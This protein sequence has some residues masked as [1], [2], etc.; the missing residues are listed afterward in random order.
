M[1]EAIIIGTGVIGAATALALVRAGW[2]V[3]S[4]DRNAVAG[5][6]S[7]S[8]SSGVV[9]MHYSTRE[10]TALAWEGTRHWQD[11]AGFL[12]LPA[13]ATLARFRQC[14][15]LVL[16]HGTNDGLA[17]EMAHGRALGIPFEEWDP[18]TI[19]DRWPGA[20]L[21]G[22][23]PPKRPDDAGFAA[24]T[25]GEIGGG[26]FWPEAGYVSDPALAAQNL[27]AAACAGGA[28]ILRGDV[29]EI[30]RDDRVAGVR[31]ADGREIRADVVVNVAGPGS[32]AINRLA[33]VTGDM[34]VGT[35]PQRME[36][37]H[38]PP[39]ALPAGAQEIIV[40]DAD[41]AVYSKPDVGGGVSVGTQG[42][43][44]D[45]PDW[46]ETD[47]TDRDTVG[48]QAEVQAMRYAMRVPQVGL[49]GRVA[50]AV[51]IYDVSDDWLPIYDR[52]S[53]PGFYMACGTSGNQFKNAPVA[54]RIMAALINYCEAGGDHDA[55]PLQFD[56]PYTG[57]RIDLGHFSRRRTAH[58]GSSFSVLG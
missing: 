7:T 2:R 3:T 23:F 13:G 33:G 30:L 58:P 12:G 36:T 10:G 8:A 51:G 31:L 39:A 28:R 46:I 48:A 38:L 40:S 29:A 45:P 11:W 15:C 21:V 9:R 41:V 24:P 18:A 42:A 50:G 47:R 37:A 20:D 14:G 57:N 22:Y 43:E 53:L 26:V 54:G 35:R 16:K 52:A 4:V 19:R 17:R 6:G 34:G 44:R 32:A 49:P 27:M 25:G 56:L 5:H 55:A 1:R